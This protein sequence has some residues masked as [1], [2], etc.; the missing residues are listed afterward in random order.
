MP[1]P[2]SDR[3]A[4]KAKAPKVIR[5]SEPGSARPKAFTPAWFT[6]KLGAIQALSEMF[7]WFSNWREVF[8]G[9]RG[10]TP[11]AP[12]RFRR[13]FVVHHSPDDVAIFTF[14]E[15]FRDRCYRRYL[16]ESQ[17]G[18][19]IDLGANI[20]LVTLDWASRLSG[21]V[22]H[23]YEPR[24]ET[25]ET[26]AVNIASN[27]LS[28][29]VYVYNEAVS[30]EQGVLV[31][32]T[33]QGSVFTSAYSESAGRGESAAIRV[34]S[35]SLD[36]VVARCAGQGTINLVKIDVEGAEAEIL[37]GASPPSLAK[38]RQFALEYHNHLCP[39]ALL[40]CE[41][42]LRGAGFQCRAHPMSD[43]NGILYARRD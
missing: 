7:I 21:V 39:D 1:S 25:F 3:S 31:I 40:R 30:G 2:D 43:N 41:S 8:D 5:T 22:I 27:H 4:V 26:L 16:D 18:V 29:R 9:Y 24:P 15:V 23:A 36:Q 13:G 34:P 32:D 19:M 38:V 28:N 6:G 33:S 14:R 12:M 42:V 37:E 20:G 17:S 11:P 10:R 35:V